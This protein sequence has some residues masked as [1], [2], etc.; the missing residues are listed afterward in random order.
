[1][2]MKALREQG[3]FCARIG[4]IN[5]VTVPIHSKVMEKPACPMF[6]IWRGNTA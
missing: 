6:S 1:M 4:D 3:Q 5:R 2:M